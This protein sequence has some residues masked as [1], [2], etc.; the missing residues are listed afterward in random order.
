MPLTDFVRYLNAQLPISA[1]ATRSTSPFVSEGGR[2]FV[3]FGDLRLDSDFS[4]IVDTASGAILG[5]AAQLQ[6]TKRERR[7]PLAHQPLDSESVFRLPNDNEEL[8]FLDR[9]VRTLHTL[10]YL[11]YGGRRAGGLLLLK[12]HPRHVAGVADDHGMAFEEILQ[13]CGLLP[14]QIT[15]ELEID[16]IDD[17]GHLERAIAN[18]QRRGYGIALAR[19]GATE[20]DFPLL[21]KSRPAYVKFDRRRLVSEQPIKDAIDA[22]HELGARAIQE[23]F[24]T[25]SSRGEARENGFDLLQVRA[26]VR[27]LIHAST[28]P[29]IVSKAQPVDGQVAA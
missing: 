9:L 5:H 11:T 3:Y 13:A 4:P 20:I 15:L 10:N 19:L 29:V 2:V 26:P 18:Y 25:E 1:F 27:R 28:S 14:K 16:G 6:A 8:I 22:L 21:H 24:D 23:G 12:V 17:T 7:Q